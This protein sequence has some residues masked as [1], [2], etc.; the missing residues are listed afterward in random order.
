MAADKDTGVTFLYPPAGLTFNYLDTINVSYTSPF[1]TPYLVTLCLRYN[2]GDPLEKNAEYGH[3]YNSSILALIKWPEF[4]SCYFT[5]RPSKT[6]GNGS[7]NTNSP[8]FR[9]N[10][11]AR[12]TPATFG[13]GQNSTTVP[14]ESETS[15]PAPSEG[16]SGGA[17]IGI[18]VGVALGCLFVLAAAV[19][20]WL[21]RRRKKARS[22]VEAQLLNK[23][24]ESSKSDFGAEEGGH[25]MPMKTIPMEMEGKA[26]ISER[27]HELSSDNALEMGSDTRV[28][29]SAG[30]RPR[31]GS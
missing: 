14:A 8:W 7:L 21:L 5:L 6:G 25:F 27:P 11:E 9:I 10:S 31:N 19:A 22:Q 23:G 2:G 28:E 13:L 30:E 17:K 24:G 18:G 26:P 4:A 15:I 20:F 1:R 29:L 3:A 16:L 12:P